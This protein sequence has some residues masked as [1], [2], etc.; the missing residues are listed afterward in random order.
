MFNIDKNNYPV[1]TQ[2]SIEDHFYV[3]VS[4]LTGHTYRFFDKED[5][6]AFKYYLNIKRLYD[7]DFWVDGD[8]IP[9]SMVAN[10]QEVKWWQD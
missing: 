5:W 3:I 9:S 10:I 6:K 1:G 8:L 7:Y 4:K 2:R